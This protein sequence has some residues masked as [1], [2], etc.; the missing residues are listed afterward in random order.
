[1]IKVKAE[2]IKDPN[3][4]AADKKIDFTKA[5]D[6]DLIKAKVADEAEKVVKAEGTT[7]F[8]KVAM[9]N[10]VNDTTT[11]IKNVNDQIKAV[12]DLNSDATKNVFSTLQVLSEQVKNSCNS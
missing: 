8:D 5:A 4:A 12:K 6:L 1:M 7:G 2:K 9:A 11:S 10:L 3:A